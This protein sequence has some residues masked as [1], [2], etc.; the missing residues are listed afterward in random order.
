MSHVEAMVATAPEGSNP[1]PATKGLVYI[2]GTYPLLTTTFIDREITALQRWGVQV[3][4]LAMR[5][6]SP[7]V[8]L[9]EH[10]RALEGAAT[11]LLP[12]AWRDLVRGHLHFILSRPVRYFGALAYLLTRP[13]PGLKARGKTLLH[14]GEGVHAAYLVRDLK[15]R[16]FHAHFVDRAA[17]V[18]LVAGRLLH[19][20][21]SL[22][23]HA[24]ADIFVDPVLVREKVMQA[25]HT[26]TCTAHNVAHVTSLVGED[27][28]H[29]M[30]RVQHGLELAEYSPVSARPNG[31]PVILSVGQLKERKGLA[32]LIEACRVLR[33]RGY[34]FRCRIVGEGPQ[35]PQLEQLIRRG[36]L[37]DVVTLSG[38]LPH[39]EVVAEYRNAT[40]FVLPCI[41]TRTGDVDGI[42]NV[43]AEAMALRVPVISTDLPAIRELVSS[44]VNGLL[45]APNDQD[46]LVGA[47]C[48][49]LDDEG[50][51]ERLGAEG[52]RTV[53]DSFDAETNVREFARTLWPEWFA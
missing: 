32:E 51:R 4:V 45:V 13:H 6:P 16:E 17:T 44:G 39:D 29:R 41:R 3:H 30:S 28:R 24:G 50:L 52:G 22:S 49:M 35:R 18:A 11:Y 33:D 46:A 26:V 8:P 1:S 48:R 19:K 31:R 21:Y 53:S 36:S 7:G 14:F 38:A 43:L 25:R 42:P 27:L 10:Q 9:S 15:F 5:R 34:R 2:M 23:I 12:A 20:P 47:M 37:E 40:M